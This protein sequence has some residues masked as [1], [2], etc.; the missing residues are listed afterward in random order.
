MGLDTATSLCATAESAFRAGL[1]DDLNISEAL[2]AFFDFMRDVNK[3]LDD[4]ALAG[5]AAEKV[6]TACRR[7]DS[8]L[9]VFDLDK[10]EDEAPAEILAL[11]EAR[12]Q[13]RQTK[14]FA[15][16]DEIRDELTDAGWVLE[17]SPTGPRVKRA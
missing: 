8:V 10:G 5:D 11:V 14:D 6:L 7:F 16:A 12:Q 13:A 15:R 4:S 1:E 9:S 3:A 2:A 17:D